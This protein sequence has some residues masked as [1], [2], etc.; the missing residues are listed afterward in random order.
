MILHWLVHP[1]REG[2]A[3][4]PQLGGDPGRKRFVLSLRKGRL[5]TDTEQP[6]CLKY[7]C[8]RREGFRVFSFFY[9]KQKSKRTKK[10][11]GRY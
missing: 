6:S 7:H 5:N 3:S 4:R 2:R 10:G 8:M 1:R 9:G 11:G